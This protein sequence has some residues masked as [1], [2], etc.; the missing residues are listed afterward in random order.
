M[1][2]TF[3]ILQSEDPSSTYLLENSTGNVWLLLVGS[4]E[5]QWQRVAIKNPPVVEKPIEGRFQLV[6]KIASSQHI[7]LL[8]TLNG[9]SWVL[10]TEYTNLRTEQARVETWFEPVA[11][12]K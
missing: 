4:T 5:P 3:K 9:A 1:R 7:V 10:K 6:G 11:A 8:D 12:P 2:W